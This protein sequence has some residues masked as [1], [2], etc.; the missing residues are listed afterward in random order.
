MPNVD[1]VLYELVM[2]FVMWLY[3]HFAPMPYDPES[4][5]F[6]STV[7]TFQH[8][9]GYWWQDPTT[10]MATWWAQ[11]MDNALDLLDPTHVLRGDH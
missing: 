10:H 1:Q 6:F 5:G 3:W 4:L 11:L 7:L 9:A 8:F 2:Q